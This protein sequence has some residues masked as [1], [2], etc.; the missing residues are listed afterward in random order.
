MK[1]EISKIRT[2]KRQEKLEDYEEEEREEKAV[3][4]RKGREGIRNPFI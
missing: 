3:I 2:R 1:S 4:M